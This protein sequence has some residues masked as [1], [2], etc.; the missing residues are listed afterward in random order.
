ML[1][2]EVICIQYL[3]HS[4]FSVYTQS[5]KRVSLFLWSKVM[6][7]PRFL[8][9]D[10]M[11]FIKMITGLTSKDRKRWVSGLGQLFELFTTSPP[12][13]DFYYFR[14]NNVYYWISG[15]AIIHISIQIDFIFIFSKLAIN[16]HATCNKSINS[17][18]HKRLR[19]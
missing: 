19:I 6:A 12:N 15:K 17:M 16:F 8:H 3:P 7:F 5:M 4:T 9:P 2:E 13:M 18:Y 10:I 11:V 14:Y 1:P